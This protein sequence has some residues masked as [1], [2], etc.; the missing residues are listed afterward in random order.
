[1]ETPEQ[2]QLQFALAGIGSRCLALLLD[3]MVQVGVAVALLVAVI[4]LMASDIFRTPWAGAIVIAAFFLLQFG[5]FIGFEIFWNGQTPGKRWTG[6]R[7]IKDSGRALSAGETI[8]R[9]LLRI[10]DQLPGCYAIGMVAMIS[11][12]SNRRLGD[13]VAGSIVIREAAVDEAR[14]S[15][16]GGPSMDA[17]S[18]LGASLLSAADIA[19]V[20]S[21]LA[22]RDHLDGATR[23]R[24]A[25][26]IV[27]HLAPKLQLNAEQMHRAETTLETLAW[28][29]RGRG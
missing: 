16:S 18:P 28:E 7:A 12:K 6:L 21:F 24:M 8:G 11:S 5:Y 20:D 3:L 27:A 9:N 1:V 25:D 26:Q 17:A 15:W 29:S 13:M 2:V 23:S 10:V 22:R 19:L 4:V 14:L